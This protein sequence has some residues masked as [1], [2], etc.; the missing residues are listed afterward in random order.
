MYYNVNVKIIKAKI[1]TV[2][3]FKSLERASDGASG[4]ASRL[5]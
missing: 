2:G 1:K 4:A 3:A 5:L